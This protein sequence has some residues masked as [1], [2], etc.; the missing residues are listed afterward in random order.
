V[1]IDFD[2]ED[3]EYVV[4]ADR[5]L[6]TRALINLLDNAVKFSPSGASVGCT[7]APGTLNGRPA[8]VCKI[9]DAGSGMA[10]TQLA[11]LF[12]KFDSTRG[13]LNGSEGIGL[14]LALVHTVITRHEGI[15]VCES[16]EGRG[17]AFT[18]TLPVYDESAAGAL[19]LAQAS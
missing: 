6:L 2:L 18:V 4:L 8:V 7:L 10:Q 9:A 3:I 11:R 19:T 17:T 1:T 16:S 15:I 14:G 12:R 13:A 5:G